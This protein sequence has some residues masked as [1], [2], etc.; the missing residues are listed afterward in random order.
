[1]AKVLIATEKPFSKVAVDGIKAVTDAAGYDLALLEKYTEKKQ[2]LDAVADADALII[3]SDKV[4]A[5]VLDAAKKLKIVVRAGAGYDNIDLEAATAHNVVAMNTPGQ[6]ANSVAELVFGLLVYGVRNFFNG[7]SGTELM[8]KKLGILAFGNV[9]RNVARIAKGFGMEVFAFDAY[10]PK[11]VIEAAGV[12]A[13]DSQEALFE[14]ADIVSLHIP[15]TPETKQSINY[16][17]VNKL[18]KGG[19]L[20]NTARKEVI[21]E[22]ELLKL[23][24]E[25]TDLK[26]VADIKPDADA[27][28]AQFEGRYFATPKKMGAQTTE[29]NT[30]AGIAAAKQINA[31]F[32]EGC[33]KFQVNK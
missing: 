16:A 1:M 9:G 2:F 20:V 12:H 17:L 6:N 3:R 28:F 30:N 5:E 4:D 7:T 10:C 29:A 21:N 31:F 33:T 8:G 25:R 11:E 32:K 27:D 15:A 18:P 26:Y 14:A 23:M 22:P 24:A 19:I 13:V